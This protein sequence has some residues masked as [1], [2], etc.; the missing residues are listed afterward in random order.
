VAAFQTSVE[1]DDLLTRRRIREVALFGLIALTAVLANLPQDYAG[2]LGINHEF[3]LAALGCAVV[4]GLF[5]YLRF[6]FFVG[7]VLLILGANLPDQIAQGFGIS[8][9]PLFLALLTMIG[10][11]LV[12]HVLKLMP[13]GLEPR[14]KEKS[15]EGIRA[16][17]YAVDKNN[18]A[19]C[20]RV[21][22]MNFD[23]NLQ[24]ENGYTPLAYAATKGNPQMVELLLGNGADP[25]QTTREG[26]TPVEL[27]LRAGHPQVA[28][29]LKQARL[30]R[31]TAL[32]ASPTPG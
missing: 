9:L 13:S 15:A 11:S 31:E 4:I 28:D 1:K 16:L 23:P 10:L 21:L 2:E 27:A 20:Q 14:P 25:S 22:A 6:F 17:L 3:L 30:E 5:L 19:Y 29:L 26:E 7:V 12:N 8:K 24:H 18:L 32:A